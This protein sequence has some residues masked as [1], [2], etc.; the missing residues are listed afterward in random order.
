M[1]IPVPILILQHPQEPS[2]KDQEVSSARILTDLI[3]PSFV[4]V[5]LSWRNLSHA[6]KGWNEVEAIKDL[7]STKAWCTLYLGT[8]T[9]AEVDPGALPGIYYL[10]KKGG[11]IEAPQS[12]RIGGLILLDGTWAQAKTLWWR[13]AWLTRIQR[14]FI[15]P[16]ARSLYG[17]IR[18]EPRPECVSTL[19]AA[20]ETLGFLGLDPAIE[21]SLKDEFGRRLKAFRKTPARSAGKP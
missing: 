3:Q 14:I 12:P 18:K 5:G 19:E 8:R 21:T 16:K 20:A 4:K 6:L 2:R 15:V 11:P 17:N 1:K 10:D 13:N 9:N 7:Q